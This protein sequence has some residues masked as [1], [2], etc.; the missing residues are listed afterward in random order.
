MDMISLRY[1][2]AVILLAA[3]CVPARAV[4]G[5]SAAGPLGG[6]DIRSAQLP[7]PGVY[8]G[9]ILFWANAFDFV[10]GNGNTIPAV[11]DGYIEKAVTGPFILYVPDVKVAGGSISIGGIVPIGRDCGQVFAGTQTEC[12]YG[13][14]DPYIEA[15]WSRGF[16]SWRPSAYAGALPIFEGLT[17]MAAFGVVVPIGTYDV[18][19]ARSNAVTL[20]NNIWTFAPAVA[21]TYTTRPILADGTEFST[22][23]FWNNYLENPD[24]SY[25]TGD[26]IDIDF[27]LTEH[28]GRWQAG[29]AGFYA[30][31]IEDDRLFDVSIPPD[32]RQAEVLYLGGVINLDAPEISSVFKFKVLTTALVENQ[33]WSTGAVFTWAHKF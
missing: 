27:A 25:S 7:P 5:P 15:S 17:V 23:V 14:G 19:L 13:A 8:G 28:V 30:F 12:L 21:L 1:F 18:D 2:I 20:G 10:D 4:E 22:K 3:A 6:T 26:L 31:Q 16:G 32:G 11:A 24:T 33:V 9:D 29:L